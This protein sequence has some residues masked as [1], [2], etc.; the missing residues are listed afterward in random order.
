MEIIWCCCFWLFWRLSKRS[1]RSSCQKLF[2][3]MQYNFLRTHPSPIWTHSRTHCTYINVMYSE[4][5]VSLL[6]IYLTNAGFLKPP[7]AQ[8]RFKNFLVTCFTDTQAGS[9][10][11]SKCS[12]EK[13]G[14]VLKLLHPSKSVMWPVLKILQ[15][16]QKH[17]WGVLL[18]S[19]FYSNVLSTKTVFK[20]CPISMRKW[21]NRTSSWAIS[22]T[23]SYLNW[24]VPFQGLYFGL[25]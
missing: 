16:N 22:N 6:W 15:K 17:R 21:E 4:P 11:V 2:H 14:K 3:G 24:P 20:H 9:V 10:A 8:V 7:L 1:L 12:A 23:V 19:V 18:F 5:N 25:Q 13:Q